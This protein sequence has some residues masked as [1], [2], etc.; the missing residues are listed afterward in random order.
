MGVDINWGLASQ[1]QNPVQSVLSAY[2][3]GQQIGQQ[4]AVKNA[5]GSF[6]AENPNDAAN[7]LI[8]AGRPD[9]A[10]NV[11][12]YAQSAQRQK[13]MGQISQDAFT[14]HPVASAM[15][16]QSPQQNP[17]SAPPGAVA[18]GSADGGDVAPVSVTGAPPAQSL[19]DLTRP[20]QT[21]YSD[22]SVNLMRQAVA[23]GIPIDHV[24]QIYSLGQQMTDPH[25]QEVAQ[26]ATA[27]SKLAQQAMLIDDPQKR[28]DFVL[29]QI[30]NVIGNKAAAQ[31]L[32]QAAQ[33][34]DY[35]DD[36]LRNFV[37]QQQG[38]SQIIAQSRSDMADAQKQADAQAVHDE[39][40]R[41]NVATEKTSSYQAQTTRLN[42]DRRQAAHGFGTPGSGIDYSAPVQMPSDALKDPED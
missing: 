1:Q 41:H 40:H 10:T 14:P 20:S 22:Q 12:N 5:L 31:Q 15:N 29:N 27:M 6:D 23:S 7:A 8:R 17:P 38:L 25:A 16:G 36:N 11:S 2:Q 37:G 28:K 19:Y 32:Y 18:P 34:F 39:T 42:S 3:Q 35:N 26:N 33:N 30:P 9:L 4:Q 24:Q 13:L 21:G